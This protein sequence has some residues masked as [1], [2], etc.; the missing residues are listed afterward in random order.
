MSKFKKTFPIPLGNGIIIETIDQE[1]IS[2]GGIIIPD[3][4]ENKIQKGKVMSIG[5]DA[6]ILVQVGDIVLFEKYIGLPM[7]INGKDYLIM[8]ES[9]ILAIV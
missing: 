5:D 2:E 8:A 1:K 7:P 3:T 6:D 9:N 4:A